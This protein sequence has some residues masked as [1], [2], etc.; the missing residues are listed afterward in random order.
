MTMNMDNVVAIEPSQ[1]RGDLKAYAEAACDLL[2]EDLTGIYL[3]G[4]VAGGCSNGK[5]SDVDVVT[6]VRES[7]CQE[8][9]E[10]LL[11]IHRAIPSPIDATY[12]TQEQARQDVYPTPLECVIRPVK[13]F[14]VPDGLPDFPIV[15]NDLHENGLCL[16][17]PDIRDV[18]PAVPWPLLSACLRDMF[19]VARKRFKNPVLMLCRIVC[20]LRTRRACSKAQAAQWAMEHFD[21]KWQL[22]LQQSMDD[23]L[24]GRTAPDLPSDVAHEFEGY[25]R[26]YA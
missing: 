19:P 10:Q 11:D 16:F 7:L 25:C 26:A 12:I 13:L 1:V 4:S 8:T 23:Y 15:R 5:T 3:Y 18:F 24:N 22:L 21:A 2:G 14:S 6:V 17:G 9:K 20:S